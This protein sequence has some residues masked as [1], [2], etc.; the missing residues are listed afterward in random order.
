MAVEIDARELEQGGH[1]RTVAARG[2][3]R[4]HPHL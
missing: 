2:P 4:V 1:R 3:G